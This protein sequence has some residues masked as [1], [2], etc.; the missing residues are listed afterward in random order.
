MDVSENSEPMAASAHG[1]TSGANADAEAGLAGAG[2]NGAPGGDRV[3][4]VGRRVVLGVAAGGFVGVLLGDRIQ[5]WLSKFSDGGTGGLGAIIPAGRFRIYNVVAELPERSTA[6]YSLRVDGLVDSPVTLTW[7]QLLALPAVDLT[8]DFQCV[9]GWRVADV[10]WRGVLLRDLLDL[11][12]VQPAAVALTFRSFDGVYTESLTLEQA[13]RDDVA[14]VY[15]M[16]GGPISA[17]HGGPARLL[18]APMY[19]YKSLKWLEAI[20]A[21]DSV[22]D[23]YW[24]VRGYETDAWVGRSNGRVDE[25]T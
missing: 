2:P 5:S 18:V 9:T 19:G 21:V 8:K 15:E 23:G 1:G 11:A 13:R 4:R 17:E 12:G 20:E 7:Q 24:E 22:E 6:E 16:Y 10:P 14:V 3:A 25:P